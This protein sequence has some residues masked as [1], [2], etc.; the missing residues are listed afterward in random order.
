MQKSPL[1]LVGAAIATV[2]CVGAVKYFIAAAQCENRTV[3][4]N[5]PQII[6]LPYRTESGQEFSVDGIP[7]GL[8]ELS[9]D[10]EITQ[11]ELSA[12]MLDPSQGLIKS[13]LMIG[14]NF[15]DNAEFELSNPYG[16]KVVRPAKVVDRITLQPLGFSTNQIYLF[17][18]P[19]VNRW[20]ATKIVAVELDNAIAL[21]RLSIRRVGGS[22]EKWVEGTFNRTNEQVDPKF[23]RKNE[24]GEGQK[25]TNIFSASNACL[26]GE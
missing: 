21:D 6:R 17:A 18:Q 16:Q 4:M 22:S 15:P 23:A 10:Q 19:Q 11:V 8:F 25:I 26:S 24:R 1:V 14:G 3:T 12:L 9:A 20:Q 13:V 2:A 5:I 7:R